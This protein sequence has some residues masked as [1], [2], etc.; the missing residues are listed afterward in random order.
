MPTRFNYAGPETDDTFGLVF[1][2]VSTEVQFLCNNFLIFF[3]R[4]NFW[5]CN[6]LLHAPC[7]VL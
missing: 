3:V 1:N 2:H 5:V 7:Q 6:D 4:M